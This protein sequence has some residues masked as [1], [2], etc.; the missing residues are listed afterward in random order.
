MSMQKI[1]GGMD[2]D[3]DPNRRDPFGVAADTIMGAFRICAADVYA[4]T[5]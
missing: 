2:D 4:N 1:R 3:E 5:F